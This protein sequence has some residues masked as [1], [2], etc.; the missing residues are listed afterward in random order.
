METIKIKYLGIPSITINECLI[1]FPFSKAESIMY[2]LLHE[3][4]VS[5]EMLS[6]LLWGDMDE[7]SAKKNLRNATYIIRKH[8]FDDIL[9]SPK[10]SILKISH[11]YNII[12]DVDIINDFNPCNIAEPKDIEKILN[13]YNGNFLEGLK[14]KSNPEFIEWVNTIGT[15]IK[16]T[17][18]NKLRILSTTLTNKEDFY[19][20]EMCCR[21]LIQLEEYDEIGYSR[22]MELYYHQR[23]YEESINIYRSLVDKLNSDLSVKP[24]KETEEIY[25]KIIKKIKIKSEK[26]SLCFYGR[27]NE[28]KIIHDNIYNFIENKSFKSLLICGEDGIGKTLLLNEVVTDFEINILKIKIECYEYETD[29]IFKFW[30]KVFQQIS[31]SLSENNINVPKGLI[32]SINKVFPTLD[33]ESS[34]NIEDYYNPSRYN[35]TEKAIFDLFNLLTRKLKIIFVVD[36]LHF[37]DKG[38]LELLYKIILANRYKILLIATNRDDNYNINDRFYYSLKYNNSIDKIYLGRFNKL[39]TKEIVSLVM[40]SALCHI[41]LIYAESEGNPLFIYELLNNFN[42]GNEQHYMTNKIENMIQGRLRHLSHQSNKILSICS[43]FH[44]VFNMEMLM[45]ITDIKPLEMIDTI[46]ELINKGLLKEKLEKDSGYVLIFTHRKIREYIYNNISNSKCF[47]LHEKIAEYHESQLSNDRKNNRTLYP[48]IIYHF[49]SSNNKFKLFKYKIRWLEYILDARHEIFPLTDINETAG[50][51]QY[52]LDDNSLDAEFEN[53]KSF[54]EELV[55]CNDNKLIEEEIIYLYLYGRF[56]K[57]KGDS[58]NGLKYLNKM[59]IISEENNYLE[60]ALKGY[61]QLIHHYVNIN[62]LSLMIKTINKAEAIA[63][64]LKDECKMAIVWRFK[65]YYNVLAGRYM[66]G[67]N[68][69]KQAIDIF[70]SAA[71]KER[72]VLN[73]MASLFYLGESYRLQE[74]YKEAMHYYEDAIELCDENEEFPAVALIFSKIGYVKYRQNKI[75]EALFYFL[76]SLKAYEKSIFVW[77]RTEVYY[78]LFKIYDSKNKKTK[79]YTYIEEALKYVDKHPNNELKDSIHRILESESTKV[80]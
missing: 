55:C 77:G 19:Y 78:Y 59:V 47:I 25:E 2:I 50:L 45:K 17:Y 5:R 44:G 11:K 70:S 40:P 10:R 75:D 52:Y 35:V 61:L 72:Y 71:N 38:S 18:V 68:C 58:S 24:S 12:S 14:L 33:I 65:G 1:K 48:E 26:N 30:D 41:D 64:L 63:E 8:T 16:N 43:L 76:K 13:V 73:M 3:K 74:I 32:D 46:D 36:D 28:K 57:G 23:K 4:V 37:V 34:G 54:Y 80:K 27:R 31:G 29:F 53:M 56:S 39:E 62:N 22:L 60:H 67:E 15:K 69:L 49:K 7:Q 51:F 6:T 21:K 20:G 42:S 9:E 66:D 79:A